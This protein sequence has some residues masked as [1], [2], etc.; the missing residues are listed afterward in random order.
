MEVRIFLKQVNVV[1]PP[2]QFIAK[3]AIKKE[4]GCALINDGW[5]FTK[6]DGD[7]WYFRKLK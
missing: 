3:I 4:E 6:N 7:D 5:T 2:N 1:N